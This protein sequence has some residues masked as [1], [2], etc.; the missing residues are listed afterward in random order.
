M[1]EEIIIN[2]NGI[3]YIYVISKEFPDIGKIGLF[4]SSQILDLFTERNI[5][6]IKISE[7]QDMYTFW[8]ENDNGEYVEKIEKANLKKRLQY[9]FDIVPYRIIFNSEIAT[10]LVY[11]VMWGETIFRIIGLTDFGVTAKKISTKEKREFIQDRKD[12]LKKMKEEF[13]CNI[14]LDT[15]YEKLNRIKIKKITSE[16]IK[17]IFNDAIAW[18]NP[19]NKSVYFLSKHLESKESYESEIKLHETIHYLTKNGIKLQLLSKEL[20][21]GATESIA[22]RVYDDGTACEKKISENKKNE[23]IYC[24]YNFSINTSYR[25][26]VSLIRQ[27]EYITQ[28]NSCDLLINGDMNFIN[29][30]KNYLGCTQAIKML[31]R[32]KKM[33]FFSDKQER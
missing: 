22:S 31:A 8:R 12:E 14:D 11:A 16:K 10:S 15:I 25:Y 1:N 9:E 4:M 3:K 6:K 13:S 32:I 33:N 18:Y 17:N 20:K 26:Y 27:L 19:I 21:E 23:E 28:A 29:S 2:Y 7:I 30:V 5:D 24:L